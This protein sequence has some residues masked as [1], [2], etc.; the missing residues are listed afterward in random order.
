MI[1][2]VAK[3]V[4]HCRAP[5]WCDLEGAAVIGAG[6]AERLVDQLLTAVLLFDS[7]FYLRSLNPA[8][9]ALLG[10]S[11]RQILGAT[12]EKCLDVELAAFLARAVVE[13]RTFSARQWE[14]DVGGGN[15]HD[16]CAVVD[17]TITPLRDDVGGFE[18]LLEIHNIDL[19]RRIAREEHMF[20]TTN[21]TTALVRGMA[22]EVKNPLAGIR[23]AAQ[24][25]ARELNSE[26][27][28]EY[29]D[30]IIGEADR[31]TNLVDSLLGPGSETGTEEVN[32]HVILDRV[33]G[34][35]EAEA[36]QTLHTVRD[37]DP[38]LP[39]LIAVPDQLLQVFLNLVR[40]AIQISQGNLTLTLRSRIERRFLIGTVL[41]KFV[42]R[43]DVID[44]G[45]GVAPEL[46]DSIFYPMVTG[47]ADGVGLGLS[48][49]QTLIHRHGG[50]IDFES[51]PG[52]TVFSVWLPCTN[53]T[54]SEET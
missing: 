49:A 52:E 33:L 37:Y 54:E 13:Q 39:K 50:F 43:V 4:D 23:G 42:A 21:V 47:R 20:E 30:I 16:H 27:Q 26:E 31:L 44:D 8:A 46:S 28:R 35:I 45:P 19:N 38:S 36:P 12:A 34:L 9:E 41:H 11:A 7:D 48:I 14:W 6:K 15:G 5:K 32:L 24:L 40:N 10:A 53:N 3:E 51:K 22:H 29:T 2:V 1:E 18:V 17:Y 25:L